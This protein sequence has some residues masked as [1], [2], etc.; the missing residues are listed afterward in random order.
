MENVHTYIHR[1][2]DGKILTIKVDLSAKEPK[3]S[4]EE[5]VAPEHYLEYFAWKL[6]ILPEIYNM[7]TPEQVEWVRRHGMKKLK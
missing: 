1:F 7:L 4:C 6:S 5:K 2:E 3:I